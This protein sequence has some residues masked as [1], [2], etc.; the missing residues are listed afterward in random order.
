MTHLV[1][2]VLGS[3]TPFHFATNFYGMALMASLRLAISTVLNVLAH[4]VS[5]SKMP[6]SAS[7]GY[8]LSSE[9]VSK[10]HVCCTSLNSVV[11]LSML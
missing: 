6:A 2:P 3:G 5:S 8:F 9:G 7:L 11:F 10:D 1:C 4:A